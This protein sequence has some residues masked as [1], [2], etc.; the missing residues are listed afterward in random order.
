MEFKPDLIRKLELFFGLLA[1]FISIAF[2]VYF[3]YDIISN[4]SAAS[5]VISTD[6]D[7]AG[8]GYLFPLMVGLSVILPLIIILSLY[9]YDVKLGEYGRYSVMRMFAVL[10]TTNLLLT[11]LLPIFI[12]S[13]SAIPSVFFTATPYATFMVEIYEII[14]EYALVFLLPII[15]FS[16][17]L[18]GLS[19]NKRYR[20]IVTGITDRDIEAAQYA[21]VSIIPILL[22]LFLYNYT[23]GGDLFTFILYAAEFV[24]LSYVFIRFGIFSSS[25]LYLSISSIDLGLNWLSSIDTATT[26]ALSETVSLF[27]LFWALIGITS[28][29]AVIFTIAGAS[30]HYRLREAPEVSEKHTSLEAK[31]T[32]R[33]K[34]RMEGPSPWINSVCPSC[35]SIT[36]KIENDGSLTCLKCGA[37]IDRDAEGP[38]NVR[39][40]YSR[41]PRF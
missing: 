2:S 28:L 5:L 16:I 10:I 11:I 33:K 12:P 3:L 8:F 15:I 13:P 29:F 7:F 24:I 32:A 39:I 14:Y 36:F 23:G 20:R 22:I 31:A 6:P 9:I 26:F 37:K 35:G 4:L 25:M 21:A 41:S 17:V 18:I 1:V 30:R 34:K 19:G 38:M 40:D 27:V